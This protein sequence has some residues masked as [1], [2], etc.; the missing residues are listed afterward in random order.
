MNKLYLNFYQFVIEISCGSQRV[1]E[2]LKKDFAYFV[3]APETP[4]LKIEAK[5]ESDLSDK[6]PAGLLAKRQNIRAMSFEQGSVRYNDFYGKAVSIIDYSSNEML[7]HAQDENILH[8]ILYL[9]VLSRETKWH[10]SRGLHKVHAFGVGK[11]DTALLGMMNM[12]GGKTTLFSYFI[13]VE[14]YELVS[15]DTPLVNWKGEVFPFPIRIGF[16][17]NSHTRERLEKY[18]DKSYRFEREEYGPKDLISLS[19]FKNP[20]ASKKKKVILFQGVRVNGINSAE[21]V[22]VTRYKMLKYLIKN[23]VIGVGLPMVLEYYLE[24]SW[25]DRFRNIKVLLLRSAAALALLS[26]ARCYEVRM[27][28]DPKENFKRVKALLDNYE[29]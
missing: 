11:G 18:R 19:E 25:K 24:S 7:V 9:A 14:G 17:L 8:E 5:I 27:G 3:S 23:M 16:E 4:L 2:L 22:K 10:D 28:E 13:D 12:K 29:K 26:N 1:L 6:I 15:D 20:V 21:I